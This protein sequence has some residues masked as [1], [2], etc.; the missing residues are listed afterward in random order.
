MQQVPAR[1]R[2]NECRSPLL[3][4]SPLA[5][6]SLSV[7]GRLREAPATQTKSKDVSS[8]KRP[9]VGAH[10]FAISFIHSTNSL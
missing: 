5:S 3:P 2:D 9:G 7:E 1:G 6:E 4:T 10:S 8:W